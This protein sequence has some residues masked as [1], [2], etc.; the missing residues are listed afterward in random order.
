MMICIVMCLSLTCEAEDDITNVIDHVSL[1]LND[2]GQGGSIVIPDKD[3][4]RNTVDAIGSEAFKG[5]T[6]I[7]SVFIP[8]T[9]TEVD[10]SAFEG[11]TG[12]KSVTIPNGVS[13]IR[14]AEFKNC[15]KLKRMSIYD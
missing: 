10:A 8:A 1:A 4:D 11:C 5:I 15:E 12:L 2:T 3:I 7:T 13:V 9:V 6:T 14:K